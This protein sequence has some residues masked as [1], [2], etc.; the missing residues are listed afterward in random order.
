[1]EKTKIQKISQLIT[2]LPGVRSIGI[3]GDPGCDGL[4]T[5]NMLVYA[6]VLEKRSI[7]HIT[8][9]VGDLL[10]EGRNS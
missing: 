2:R 4:G 5:F 10:R 1:M 6:G 9:V 7:Y 8:I 3:I